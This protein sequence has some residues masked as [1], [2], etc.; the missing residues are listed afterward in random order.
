[1]VGIF[2]KE[3]KYIGLIILS[4][5]LWLSVTLWLLIANEGL[6]SWSHYD[7]LCTVFLTLVGIC[8]TWLTGNKITNSKYNTPAGARGLRATS[9]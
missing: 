3:R 4:T 9:W 1:M 6:K 2:R 5:L 8:A 7:Q